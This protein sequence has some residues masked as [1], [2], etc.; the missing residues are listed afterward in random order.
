MKRFTDTEKWAG[1]VRGLPPEW[2]LFW[3]YLCDNCDNAGVWKLD[4]PLASFCCGL[5]LDLAQA[6]AAL[7][8]RLEIIDEGQ[9]LFVPSFIPFQYGKLSPDCPAHKHVFRLLEK[10][11]LMA[12][13]DG[14]LPDHG[15]RD[16][17]SSWN[18]ARAARGFGPDETA[19]GDGPGTQAAEAAHAEGHSWP[20]LHRCIDRHWLTFDIECRS[21]PVSLA[22]FFGQGRYKAYLADDWTP[23]KSHQPAAAAPELAR[24]HSPKR[25]AA[26]PRPPLPQSLSTDTERWSAVLTAFKA[27]MEPDEFMAWL[28]C[29]TYLGHHG[30]TLYLRASSC[31]HASWTRRNHEDAIL[32]A[33]AV[34]GV[35]RLD[36]RVDEI[37][38]EEE[39]E[40]QTQDTNEATPSR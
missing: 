14:A 24:S 8:E 10:H 27:S 38:D 26:K 40:P 22:N 20:I 17:A 13:G 23:P 36:V 21:Y 3:V 33:Y 39:S 15:A 29:L 12:N 32:A 4:M 31:F 7:L 6:P 2:K 9:R 1:W 25:P 5:P 37:P 19:A 16:L 30:E 34:D 35:A 11:G 28:P 18:A